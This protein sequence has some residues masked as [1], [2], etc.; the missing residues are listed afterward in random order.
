MNIRP[1]R[2]AIAV[3]LVHFV[4]TSVVAATEFVLYVG[5]ARENFRPG[6]PTGVP[7]STLFQSLHFVRVTLLAPV[8]LLIEQSG[9]PPPN[10]L[11][12]VALFF[13]INSLFFGALCWLALALAVQLRR[14]R[15]AT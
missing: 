9:Y 2:F 12:I 7:S 13:L 3:T 1:R 14:G 10:N 6:V 11:G 5:Y 4:T 8:R 15:H